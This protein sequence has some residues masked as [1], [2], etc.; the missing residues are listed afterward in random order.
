MVRT[1]HH[2]FSIVNYNQPIVAIPFNRVEHSQKSINIDVGLMDYMAFSLQ[3]IPVY[4]PKNNHYGYGIKLTAS[5]IIEYNGAVVM[6]NIVQAWLNLF[7]I[8]PK[9]FRLKL[10]WKFKDNE[11]GEYQYS[12]YLRD[13]VIYK[14][15]QLLNY[16]T[17]VISKPKEVYI[18]HVGVSTLH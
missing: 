12:T 2:T 18:L 9:T 11:D 3:W 13:E 14:L 6:K 5:T 17:L 15:D 1:T 8:A 4:Y 16:S 7:T 10:G